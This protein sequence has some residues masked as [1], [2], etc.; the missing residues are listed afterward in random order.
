MISPAWLAHVYTALGAPLALLATLMVLGGDYRN[1]F[2]VLAAA[3]VID[4]TD[5][6]LARWLR[7][8]EVLP[9]FDGARLDDIV[10]YLTYVFVPVLLMLR[11]GLLPPG[12]GAL[13]ANCDIPLRQAR[14][15]S[16]WTRS[17]R[18]VP[19]N[20]SA[21]VGH[22]IY[23]PVRFACRPEVSLLTLTPA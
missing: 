17:G 15:L 18:T 2:I 11:A 3:T 1:A 7:V 19:L 6:W 21:G 9:G 20:V 16:T 10:D 5:G 13:V 4:T 23:A 22:S 12:W 8:K 14:G